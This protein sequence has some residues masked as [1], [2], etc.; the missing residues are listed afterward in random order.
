MPGNRWCG[1]C[2]RLLR[3]PAPQVISVGGIAAIGIAGSANAYTSP[4]ALPE[5]LSVD[6]Q[7]ALV[8]QQLRENID[9]IYK[10]MFQIQSDLHKEI[11]Q[12]KSEQK[13]A[14]EAAN[15][16]DEEN[17]QR[18]VSA[19]R[20]EAYGFFLLALGTMIQAWGSYLGID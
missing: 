14:V 4:G 2:R 9:K 20:L 13:L 19:V 10:R 12:A 7:V 3:R 16:L 6:D 15:A 8:R 17:R 18:A 5:G 1:E 11:E